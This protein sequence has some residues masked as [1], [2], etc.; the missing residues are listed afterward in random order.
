MHGAGNRRS[1]IGPMAAAPG[2]KQ[3]R[4]LAWTASYRGWH[5]PAMR[6]T[7]HGTL[8]S[9]QASYRMPPAAFLPELPASGISLFRWRRDEN[10][11]SHLIEHRVQAYTLSLILRP[12]SAHAWLGRTS[13]WSGPIRADTSRLT[14]PDTDPSWRS[15]GA[16]DFLLLTIPCHTIEAI[17][18][19]DAQRIHQRL[20]SAHPSYAHD[21]TLL[22]IG[23]QM[24]QACYSTAPY[25]R[26]FA[27]GLGFALVAH[28]LN[29][30]SAAPEALK[31]TPLSP[32]SRSSVIRYIADHLSETILVAQLAQAAKLS[33]S[34][35]AHAFRASM[36]VSPHRFITSMRIRRAQ[37]LLEQGSKSI[38][39]IVAE[40]GFKDASHFARVFRAHTHLTPREFR[41]CRG[42]TTRA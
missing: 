30:C 2:Q 11:P 29:H 38:G 8:Q 23:R 1:R 37:E 27:D 32:F 3:P 42:G 20:R 31:P 21:A 40:C 26:S 15:D 14:P 7:A 16:F 22:Q 25:A 17:A 4:R 9:L 6:D 10:L 12:M 33:E 13:I 28:L 39:Q 36:G 34:H 24:L 19:D 5:S 18:G 41:L 35:F